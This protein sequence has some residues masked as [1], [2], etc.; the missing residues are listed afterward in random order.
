MEMA[1]G[2][3]LESIQFKNN[4]ELL[5]QLAAKGIKKYKNKLKTIMGA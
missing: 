4:P 2:E 3:M 1:E 5:V